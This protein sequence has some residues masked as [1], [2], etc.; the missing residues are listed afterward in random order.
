MISSEFEAIEAVF[1]SILSD[2]RLLQASQ[3]FTSTSGLTLAIKVKA[4][5]SQNNQHATDVA[6]LLEGIIK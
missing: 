5:R 4:L 2:I 6:D 3:P 1:K